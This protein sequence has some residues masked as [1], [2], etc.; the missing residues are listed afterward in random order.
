MTALPMSPLVRRAPPLLRDQLAPVVDDIADGQRTFLHER[1]A[2]AEH[3][4]I[5]LD[6]HLLS[7]QW[8]PEDLGHDCRGHGRRIPRD[9][10]DACVLLGVVQSRVHDPFDGVLPLRDP[11]GCESAHHQAADAGVAWWVH[12]RQPVEHQRGLVLGAGPGGTVGADVGVGEYRANVEQLGWC[13]VTVT[14]TSSGSSVAESDRETARTAQKRPPAPDDL[15][16]I[17]IECEAGETVQQGADS[18]S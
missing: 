4:L 3:H 6:H 17:H 8:E 11:P 5:G 2:G 15:G 7:I 14:L 12:H 9:D 1:R 10:V 18:D 13:S 16:R